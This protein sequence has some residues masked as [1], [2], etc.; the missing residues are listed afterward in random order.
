[1]AFDANIF[2]SLM[3]EGIVG[4]HDRP[5]LHGILEADRVALDYLERLLPLGFDKGYHVPFLRADKSTPCTPGRYTAP[6]AAN[7]PPSYLTTSRYGPPTSLQ[8]RRTTSL[9]P[10]NHGLDTVAYTSPYLC[11]SIMAKLPTREMSGA[12][13]IADMPGK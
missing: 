3:C 13:N 11:P 10:R 1:M 5:Q 7:K 9:P 6:A 8:A 2:R 4:L 12:P